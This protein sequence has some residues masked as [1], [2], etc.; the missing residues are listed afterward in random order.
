[1][2][3]DKRRKEGGMKSFTYVITDEFGMHAR[4]A[5]RLVKAAGK[6]ASAVTVAVGDKTVD[7]KR[8]FALMQLGVKRGD[9]VQVTVAGDDEDA[10]CQALEQFFKENL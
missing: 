5:G 2:T 6:Y 10:A 3:I 1:L 4:P 8:L 9:D 7:A